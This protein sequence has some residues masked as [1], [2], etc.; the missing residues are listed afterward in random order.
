MNSQ[1]QNRPDPSVERE[2]TVLPVVD[3]SGPLKVFRPKRA[4]DDGKGPRLT[5]ETRAL[6]WFRLRAAA[7]ILLVG[8]G[9]F[10]I[11]HV[12]GVLTGE[13][14]HPVLLGFHVVVVLV[15]GFSATPLFRHDLLSIAETPDR[16]ACHLWPCPPRFF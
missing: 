16:R 10:L 15:L 13:P 3:I 7:L 2:T 6:L 1:F 12:A 14:R 9:V 11:R 8:F 5:N 4:G